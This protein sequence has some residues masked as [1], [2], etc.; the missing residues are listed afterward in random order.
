MWAIKNS[1]KKENKPL[2]MRHLGLSSTEFFTVWAIMTRPQNKL[3]IM[4]NKEEEF[5]S[6]F[7]VKQ[8]S[9]V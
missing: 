8:N 6:L 9:H 1:A 2:K 3:Q 5:I 7:H 4:R